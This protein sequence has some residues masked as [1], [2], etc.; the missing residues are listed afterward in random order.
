MFQQIAGINYIVRRSIFFALTWLLV[1]SVGIWSACADDLVDL[2]RQGKVEAEIGGSGIQSVNVRLRRKATQTQIVVVDVPVGTFFVAANRSTQS[3]VSTAPVTINLSGNEWIRITVAAACANKPLS[4]P[5]ENDSFIVQRLPQQLEL[6]KV[7]N[8]LAR[9]NAS[10]PVI[11]AAVWIITDNAT[12]DSLGSLRVG[13]ARAIGAD[14]AALAMKYVDDSGIDIKKRAIWRDRTRL[15]LIARKK[16]D[17]NWLNVQLTVGPLI[18][19][20]KDTDF[21]VRSRAIDALGEIKDPRAVGPLIARLHDA[22]STAERGDLGQA[23]GKIKDPR[24][25]EPLIA[26]L[27][28]GDVEVITALGKIKDPRAVEPLIAAL[29]RGSVG[30]IEALGEIGDPRAV[31]PL[32]AALKRGDGEVITALGKIK[33]PRAMGAL[34]A[35]VR[36]ENDTKRSVAIEALGDGK[37]PGAVEVLIAVLKDK[38][39]NIRMKS[40]RALGK[41]KDPR[42]V[43]SLT[44]I[45]LEDETQSVRDSAAEALRAIQGF[46]R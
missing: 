31:E 15:A 5:H 14:D 37:D 8:V 7:I 3:M 9:E 26:A 16:Q 6:T 46:I 2:I 35:V 41:L 44:T 36:D 42:A 1:I 22:I 11:Q 38:N 17:V 19:L 28:R 45:V 10:Y 30:A 21:E 18:A 13:L 33:D 23:L 4:I 32:I 20:L 34:S 43:A 24:A 40:V 29:K 12:Y 25:V 27:K 39:S